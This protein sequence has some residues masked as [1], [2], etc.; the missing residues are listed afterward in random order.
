MKPYDASR[1]I[2]IETTR[3]AS[4]ITEEINKKIAEESAKARKEHK[5]GT[6]LKRRENEIIPADGNA[7]TDDPIYFDGHLTQADWDR[8][9][10]YA[11]ESHATR[12]GIYGAYDEYESRK[13]YNEDPNDYEPRVA[14][15]EFDVI[16]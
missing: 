13:S 16:L 15:W 9:V 10:A 12:I 4:G 6:F 8:A 7:R 14:E 11:K 2:L 5:N 1:A 3:G